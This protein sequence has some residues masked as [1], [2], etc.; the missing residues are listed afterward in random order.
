MPRNRSEWVIAID[1]P[2]G[3]GKSTIS[4]ML[5]KRLGFRYID[6]GAMYRALAFWARHQGISLEDPIALSRLGKELD[7]VYTETPEGLRVLANGKDVTE[8]L[9][10]PGV[11]EDASLI[12]RFPEVRQVLVEKQ[13]LLGQRG[14]VV[15]EGRDIGSVV[16]P[17]ADLKIFLDADV[18]ERVR[19]RVLQ[20]KTKGI[21][22]PRERLKDEIQDRD[23]RDSARETAPLKVAE[24]A[25]RIDTTHLTK[26]EVLDEIEACLARIRESSPGA[27]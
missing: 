2:S 24:G 17:D 1:G 13:R 14:G 18:E 5:A 10:K 6:T 8:E 27:P 12:S 11:G 9:R 7:I 16:F 19:R 22:V 20:W 23:A 26:E 25:V 4:R 21:E 15:M 3:V